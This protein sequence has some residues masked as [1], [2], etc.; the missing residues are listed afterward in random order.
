MKN[1]PLVVALFLLSVTVRAQSSLSLTLAQTDSIFLKHNL[2]LLA[3]QYALSAQ[4][5]LVVQA[6][7]YPNP[8]FTAD[9]NAIDPQNNETFHIGR[10]GE[11]AFSVEQLIILG[12]K[13]RT[14]INIARQ[15]QKIAALELDD[16]LRNLRQQLHS[17]FFSLYQQ[18]VILEKYNR[19]LQV[20]DTLIASYDVQAS[21]GNLPL[22]DVIRLKAVYLKINNEKSTL[23]SEHIEEQRRMQMLLQGSDVI[24]PLVSDSSFEA[25]NHLPAYEA[26][27]DSASR[28]R[29][30]L[31][32]AYEETAL[33]LLNLRLQKRNAIPDIAL[34][35]SYDQR[36]GAFINQ[37]NVGISIPL[38]LWNLNRGNIRAAEYA[39]KSSALY[40]QQ[41]K[42]E[43]DTDVQ[44]AW[45]DMNLSLGEYAK[46]KRYY[47]DDFDVVFRGI[48]DNFQKHNISILEFVD[49]FESYNESLSEYERVRNH[50][51]TSAIQINYVTATQVY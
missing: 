25:F 42:L 13:R 41:K 3:Q 35:G 51:A 47:S 49:F 1:I 12:G 36:G 32:M 22:K 2:M 15:N 11:K 39:S 37:W 30:D 14:E 31:K 9:L 23:A 17:S 24:V 45:Q 4:E 19:Q 46:V 44:A 34:N 7:A 26:L 27:R 21:R 8:T 38:P 48:N 20:L 50:L 43:V 5:A 16:L 28:R 40:Q 18:R 33:S 6:R 29:P 10:T